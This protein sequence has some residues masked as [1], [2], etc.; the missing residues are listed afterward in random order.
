MELLRFA[1]LLL[2][3]LCVAFVTGHKFPIKTAVFSN[4][5][6][7]AEFHVLLIFDTDH[8]AII[9]QATSA[10]S[11]EFTNRTLVHFYCPKEGFSLKDC[12]DTE[13]NNFI[14]M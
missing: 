2:V 11:F 14:Y 12:I 7:A 13:S 1:T 10:P 3:L 4:C 5:K 6:D 8:D 9:S